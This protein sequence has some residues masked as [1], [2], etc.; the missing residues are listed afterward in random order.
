V[1]YNSA[2]PNPQSA[3]N[4]IDYRYDRIGNM[5]AQTSDIDQMER[6]Q[7]VTDLGELSY[8]GSLGP[9]GRNGRNPLIH[10]VRTP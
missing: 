3:T 6:G 10:P 4:F 8:G 1:H 2:T 9:Q 5:L 7:P